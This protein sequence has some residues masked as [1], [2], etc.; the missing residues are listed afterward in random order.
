M[1]VV[2]LAGGKGTRYDVD[3]PKSLATIGR[4]PIIHHLMEIYSEQGYNDFIL[5]L[6]WR[7][8]D[9]INYF[10]KKE[11]SFNITFV[12]TKI[13]SNTGKRLKLVEK[14]IPD[15]DENFLCNYSDGLANVD[16]MKLES[17]HIVHRNIATLTA[18]KPRNQ[19]GILIFDK[20]DNVIK[21]IEKPKMNQYINGGFFIFNKKIFNYID[22]SKNQELEKDILSSLAE[23]NKLGA[24]KHE[25][26]WKTL[27]TPKDEIELNIIYNKCIGQNK[28]PIWLK[29]KEI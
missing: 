22:N 27:N 2:I 7:Q 14:Y 1:K 3:K 16:L 9:I 8:E 12:D 11:H 17:R 6:G 5:A 21:F 4:K 13:E 25:S 28:E 15:E 26:F 23:E 10:L 19:F 29:C 20:N 24:Y 18:I